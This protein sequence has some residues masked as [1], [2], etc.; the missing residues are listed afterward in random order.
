ME[1]RLIE[2]LGDSLGRCYRLQGTP[3]FDTAYNVWRPVY[4]DICDALQADNPAFDFM[5]FQY[6]IA[7]RATL[8]VEPVK[9]GIL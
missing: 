2:I 7:E 4:E 9:T 8:P 5:R 1:T 6:L 3:D